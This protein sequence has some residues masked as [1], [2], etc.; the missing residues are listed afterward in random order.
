MSG[1]YKDLEVWESAM[2]MVFDVYRDMATFPKQEMF[3]LTSQLRRAAMSVASNIAEGKGRFSDRELSQFLS[4]A[5]GS[6]FEIENQVAIALE[7]AYLTKDQSQDLQRPCAEVG[8]L[9]NGLI[10]AVRKPAA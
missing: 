3:G 1:T 8:R 9:L 2:K 10:K 4:V 5:R 7:L 6:V